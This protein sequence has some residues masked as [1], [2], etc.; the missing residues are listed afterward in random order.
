MLELLIAF[1]SG[2]VVGWN[3]LPQPQWVAD[4]YKKV[5]SNFKNKE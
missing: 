1:G 5:M 2:L 3:V 4:L